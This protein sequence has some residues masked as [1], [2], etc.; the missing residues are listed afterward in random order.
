MSSTL[1]LPPRAQLC[2]RSCSNKTHTHTY[3]HFPS[4]SPVRDGQTSPHKPRLVV[5]HSTCPSLSPSP[6]RTQLYNRSCSNKHTLDDGQT[7]H[8]GLGSWSLVA[9]VLHSP[10]PRLANS[11]VLGTAVINTHWT[12]SQQKGAPKLIGQCVPLQRRCIL[13]GPEE[14][15]W[16]RG[17]KSIGIT[18]EPQYPRL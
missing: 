15:S 18:D 16:F 7:V 3:T 9:H 14:N 4:R 6:P 8:R 2:N 5:P 11:F 1:L 17:G 12:A 10:P 13:H